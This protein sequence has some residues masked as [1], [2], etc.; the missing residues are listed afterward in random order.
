MNRHRTLPATLLFLVALAACV[1]TGPD[2]VTGAGA[3][4][5]D[6]IAARRAFA[7]ALGE[8]VADRQGPAYRI[9][10]ITG[11]QFPVGSALD[12]QNPADE[13]APACALPEQPL[14]AWAPLPEITRSR[15]I[16]FG[17]QLPPLVARTET[18]LTQQGVSVSAGGTAIWRMEDVAQRLVPQSSFERAIATGACRAETAGRDV[19]FVRG[20]IFSRELIESDRDFT[21]SGGFQTSSG[22]ISISV[23]DNGAFRVQDETAIARYHIVTLKPAEQI[24]ATT[25]TEPVAELTAPTDAMLRRLAGG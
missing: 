5:A 20:I 24:T 4:T 25:S 22:G 17:V 16:S 11:P 8:A 12:P 21:A 14:V 13:V 19:L 10:A 15:Q 6:Y 9:V 23:A 2:L 3:T 18:V 7:A 1:P